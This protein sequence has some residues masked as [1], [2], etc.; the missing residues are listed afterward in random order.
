[1]YPA[2]GK[3][4]R[5]EDDR[6]LFLVLFLLSK[7]NHIKNRSGINH[8]EGLFWV[9]E[10]GY[11]V[12]AE[13]TRRKLQGSRRGRI[14]SI[15]WCVR[16]LFYSK[17]YVDILADSRDRQRMHRNEAGA[18]VAPTACQASFH[19]SIRQ[20]FSLTALFQ[21]NVTKGCTAYKRRKN[22]KQHNKNQHRALL[23][24]KQVSN[25]ILKW[26]KDSDLVP[27]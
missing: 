25:K 6:F 20:Y 12:A 5:K 23:P 22:I 19:L 3:K 16:H 9:L 17:P 10:V 7:F 13:N 18:P 14:C 24:T 15:G 27:I 8:S 11:R 2:K 21:S 4:E 26:F 1:M